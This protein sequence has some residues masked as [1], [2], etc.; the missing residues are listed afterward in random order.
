MALALHLQIHNW[1]T[2]FNE[3]NLEF[4]APTKVYV[5]VNGEVTMLNLMQ[6]PVSWRGPCGCRLWD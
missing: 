1:S 3:A 5:S 6:L 2:D 4:V